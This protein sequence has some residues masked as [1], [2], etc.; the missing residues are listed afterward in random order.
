MKTELNKIQISEILNG[1]DLGKY[2]S[3]KRMWWSIKNTI[4]LV[5]TTK[6][7]F[8]LKLFDNSNFKETL[9]TLYICEKLREKGIPIPETF[10]TKEG[11]FTSKYARNHLTIQKFLK[12]TKRP[13]I[14]KNYARDLAKN[15]ALIDLYLTKIRSNSLPSRFGYQFS[16]SSYRSTDKILDFDYKSAEIKLIDETRKNV[17]KDK[18]RKGVIHSDFTSS[19]LIFQNKCIRAVLDWDEIH[20]DYIA[21]DPAIAISHMITLQKK[22][23]INLIR[24]FIREYTLYFKLNDSEKKAIFYF[25]KNRLLGAIVWCD[26]QRKEHKDKAKKIGKWLRDIIS[27]YR[28]FDKISL[29]EFLEVI[30]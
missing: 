15:L 6:G 18:L 4:Y 21:S 14:N 8:I 28:K 24:D 1:Y 7:E 23:S 25:I 19:N 16:I 10:K 22:V 12:G 29:D 2:K 11:S 26:L 13:E 30:D 5:K 20:R 9:P 3:H 17:N 27:F